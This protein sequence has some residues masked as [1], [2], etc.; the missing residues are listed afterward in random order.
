ML[1]VP[2]L[3]FWMK[4]VKFELDTLVRMRCYQNDQNDHPRQK[5]RLGVKGYMQQLRVH[6][7]GVIRRE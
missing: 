2:E 1:M 4:T 5:A 6:V 3:E 7:Y